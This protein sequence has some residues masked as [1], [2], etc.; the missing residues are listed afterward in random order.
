MSSWKP[1]GSS[2]TLRAITVDGAALP[3]F[4]GKTT[5]YDIPVTDPNALPRVAAGGAGTITVVQATRSTMTARVTVSRAYA[6]PTTYLVRFLVTG[7]RARQCGADR[8]SQ[9]VERVFHVSPR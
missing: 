6:R 2:A 1:M 5:S 3:A 4:S 8:V 7:D 9:P